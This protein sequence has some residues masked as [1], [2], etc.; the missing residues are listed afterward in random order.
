MRGDRGKPQWIPLAARTSLHFL[1]SSGPQT[2][3][4]SNI[5]SKSTH[6]A[7]TVQSKFQRHVIIR[8]KLGAGTVA[9]C[10]GGYL[11]QNAKLPHV[12]KLQNRFLQSSFP[13][14]LVKSKKTN[15]LSIFQLIIQC[16]YELKDNF[17]LFQ[18]GTTH[19]RGYCVNMGHALHLL[20]QI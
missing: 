19:K 10:T 12:V 9:R 18:S 4:I 5:A 14:L 20:I 8:V 2:N 15:T 6:H 17:G 13:L 1:H 7:A 3:N 11:F 16:Y